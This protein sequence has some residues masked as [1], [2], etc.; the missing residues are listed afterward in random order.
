M[1]KTFI[2]SW[3]TWLIILILLCR[4]STIHEFNRVKWVYA[5]LLQRPLHLMW[6]KI[7]CCF[8]YFTNCILLIA[9]NMLMLTLLFAS[10]IYI[11][12]F[13]RCHVNVKIY[14][15]MYIVS[16]WQPLLFCNVSISLFNEI[17]TII[18]FG[19]NWYIFITQAL[20]TYSN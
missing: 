19:S 2:L 10:L 4:F 20:L 15:Y 11:I 1:Y 18:S 17:Q 8:Y 5:T 3:N 6:G 13:W 9:F 7:L 14:I 16:N 12:I